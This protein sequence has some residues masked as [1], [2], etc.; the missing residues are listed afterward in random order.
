[1]EFSSNAKSI[2]VASLSPKL[3]LLTTI[4]FHNLYPL[5]STVYMKLSRALFFHDLITNEEIDVC[6]HIFHILA[7]TAERIASRNY[8]PF[9]RLISKILKL[10]GV[11]PTEDEHPYPQPS[12]INICTLNASIGHT[13]K[14]TKQES[15][16]PSSSSSSSHTY[17]EKLN[18]IMATLQE[19]NTK[20]SGLATIMHSQIC[21]DTKFTSLQTQLDQI[22][23]KL[24]EHED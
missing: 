13:R 23:R 21:F 1:M 17:D 12:P 18:N 15:H 7:K 10:K 14:S 11:H 16:A 22:Q 20:I 24:E 8:L 9:C 3:R 2:S 19:I 5:S 4:M 6:S